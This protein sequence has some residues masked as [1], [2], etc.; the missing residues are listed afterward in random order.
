[1]L[2]VETRPPTFDWRD[3]TFGGPVE[4]R[5]P[6]KEF[7]GIAVV[8]KAPGSVE[9]IDGV[10]F[11]GKSGDL[12]HKILAHAGIESDAI[13]LANAFRYQP[14]WT[15][16][17]DGRR[18]DNDE[19]LFFTDERTHG[20]DKLPPY[21]NRWVLAGPDDDVRELWRTLRRIR[22]K[23]VIACGAIATWAL[24]GRDQISSAAGTFLETACVDAPVMA[25]Y[26]PAYA[27][28]RDAEDVAQRIVEDF[29]KARLRAEEI[30]AAAA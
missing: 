15:V 2:S 18:R 12:L 1:M 8:G 23:V 19:S 27:L 10:P 4:A 6:V 30:A 5:L 24:T 9:V 14:A 28:R 22:P 3:M 7:N 29:V 26:H 20:N 11:S 17:E 13:L 16:G 25:T 21:Q